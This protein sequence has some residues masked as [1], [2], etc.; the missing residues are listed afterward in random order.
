MDNRKLE[1]AD[2]QE[3]KFFFDENKGFYSFSKM[4]VL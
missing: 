1:K 2:L 4:K 3:R